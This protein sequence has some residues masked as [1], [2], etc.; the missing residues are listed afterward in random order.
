[1]RIAGGLALA[2]LSGA[3]QALDLTVGAG[4]VQ[5]CVDAPTG[6]N[7]NASAVA[8]LEPAPVVTVNDYGGG[9]YSPNSGN[10]VGIGVGYSEF[11][12]KAAGFCIGALYRAEYR[13]EASK[14]LLDGLVADHFGHPFDAG[15]TYRLSLTEESFKAYGLRVRRIANFDLTNEWVLK[16]GIGVS[17]LKATEGQNQSLSGAVT[18]SSSTYA[19]GTATWLKSAS[20]LNLA[21]FNPFVARGSPSGDGFSS[22]VELLAQSRGGLSID[23]VV[24]DALGRIYW[25]DVPRSLRTFNNATITYNSNFDRDAFV[26]GVD[27]RVKYVQNIAQK[28]HVALS[29][30]V[31][32]LPRLSVVLEDD[33][34]QGLHFPS[35]GVRSGT[36]QRLAEVNFDVRTKALGLGGRWDAIRVLV[37]ANDFRLDRASVLGISL[38]ASHTW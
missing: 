11:T 7:F 27:S 24:M 16:A 37:T 30:P 33:F 36:E 13:A 38:Q 21:N 4:A 12:G 23:L 1:M 9:H 5:N 14:D 35:L 2:I 32:V 8:Y 28:Y 3:T 6:L 15:R 31:P 25:R 22:D 19:V 26:N 20:N 10:D 18:A 17:L 29:A 34:I